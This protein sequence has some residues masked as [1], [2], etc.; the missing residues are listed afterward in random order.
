MNI[1]QLSFK[2]LYNVIKDCVVKNANKLSFQ[3]F[4][5][6]VT[7]NRLTSYSSIHELLR[8]TAWKI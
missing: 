8:D 4:T 7:E 3:F 2:W 6:N 1:S 5:K